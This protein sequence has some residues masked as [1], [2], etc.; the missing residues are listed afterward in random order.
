MIVDRIRTNIKLGTVIPKPEAT[1]KFT[2]K[3][4]GT[5]RGQDALIYR[6]PNYSN[7]SKPSE[8][9]I[10]ISEFTAACDQLIKAGSFTREWFNHALRDC[11]KEGGCNF[12]TIGGVFELLCIVKYEKRGTYMFTAP[13]D[14]R[15]T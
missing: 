12:T 5:R 7:P 11:A 6:I 2:V 3:G 13:D 8:K 14:E 10:T 4:W 15:K 9:G 1:A